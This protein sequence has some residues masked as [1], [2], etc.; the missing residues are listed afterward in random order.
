[1]KNLA[2]WCQNK[3]LIKKLG[4]QQLVKNFDFLEETAKSLKGNDSIK[5]FATKMAL[6]TQFA[7]SAGDALKNTLVSLTLKPE[8]K[9]AIGQELIRQLNSY[10]DSDENLERRLLDSVKD[11]EVVK[12]QMKDSSRGW[13]SSDVVYNDLFFPTVYDPLDS[14]YLYFLVST[15]GEC[16]HKFELPKMD[17]S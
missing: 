8:V 1:M 9:A 2:E 3:E 16:N 5:A 6:S 11:L 17:S 12:A 15:C 4:Y 13:R 10:Q 7:S 14:L